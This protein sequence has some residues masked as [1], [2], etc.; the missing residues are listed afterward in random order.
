VLEGRVVPALTVT[1][2]TGGLTPVQLAQR[3]VGP[4]V[5]VSNVTSTGSPL[6]AGEFTGGTGIIGFESGIILSSGHA[7][8]VPGPNNDSAGPEPSFDNGQPGDPQLDAIVTPNSTF[9]ASVL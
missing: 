7:N 1:D 4:G 6:A 3:L 2:L 5:T 9:D 8:G